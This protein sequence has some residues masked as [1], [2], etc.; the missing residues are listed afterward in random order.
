MEAWR[1]EWELSPIFVA[2]NRGQCSR[3]ATIAITVLRV[4]QG[5]GVL[6]LAE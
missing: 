4:R 2:C 3:L 1:D 6:S 5:F